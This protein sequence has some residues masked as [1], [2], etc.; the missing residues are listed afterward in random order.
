V[1]FFLVAAAAAFWANQQRGRAN[2]AASEAKQHQFAAEEA[3]SRAEA[4]RTRAEQALTTAKQERAR[5]EAEQRRA[6]AQ[7]KEA[8][9]QRKLAEDQK[10][11]AIEQKQVAERQQAIA[12]EQK[13][14]AEKM[15]RDAMAGELVANAESLAKG[16]PDH[17][18]LLGLAAWRLSPIPK[19]G[20]LIR[21]AIGDYSNQTVLRG[22]EARVDGA[23]FSP[24]GK[25]VVTAS[26]D[27]TARLWDAASGTQLHVLRGHEDSVNGAQFSPDGKTVVT[28]SGRGTIILEA[29]RLWR[30]EVCRPVDDIAAELQRAVGRELTED[31][32]QR[33]GVPEALFD[34]E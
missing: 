28:A 17:T 5:A 23:Q 13:A 31:E 3:K 9:R 32:R 2:A 18:A 10:Q 29:A 22:H 7:T 8:E 20:A 26:W 34:K 4:E 1:V 30:C 16:H 19:A 21:A 25:T 15:A 6:E 14:R 24:D 27:R 11:V 33:F 12:T